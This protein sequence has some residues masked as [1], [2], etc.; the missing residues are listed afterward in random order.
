MS[1][2]KQSSET[3]QATLFLRALSCYEPDERIKGR[4]NFARLFLPDE[5]RTKIGNENYRR[6]AFQKIKMGTYNY[7]IART[8]WFDRVFTEALENETP[9][10]VILG[11]GYDARAYRYK[12]INRS[13]IIFEVDALYTQEEKKN[14]LRMNNIDTNDVRFVTADFETDDL[15]E[16]L[17]GNG[18]DETK[19]SLFL[20]EGVTLYLTREAVSNTLTSVA[21]VSEAGS[22]LALDYL[23]FDTA[24]GKYVK[25]DE[26]IQ[27]GMNKA[28][29]AEFAGKYGFTAV[30]NLDPYEIEGKFLLRSNGEPFGDTNRTM[31][32]IKLRRD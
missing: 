26:I 9:Q 22:M 25:R 15:T 27:F 3:A 19:R 1:V 5:R 10:I 29:M 7:V 2:Q 16:I 31:N 12:D 11:A 17:S 13:T 8:A 28:E 21:S 18:F 30:E 6:A 14:I 24:D 32:F 4:D 23:N 20:W